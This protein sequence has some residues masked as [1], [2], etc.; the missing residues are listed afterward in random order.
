MQRLYRTLLSW[1]KS[2][3]RSVAFLPVPMMFFGLLVGILLYYL[4][5]NTDVSARF[6]EWLP[7]VMVSSQETARSILGLFVGGLIT[8][9]VFTFTQMMSLFNQV[10]NSYIPRLLPLFTGDRSLQ[11]TMGFYLATIIVTLIV[12]LS[13]RSDDGGY[14]PNLSVLFCIV[15]GVISLCM[16]MYFVTTISDKIKVSSIIESVYLRGVEML[17]REQKKKNFHRQALPPNLDDWYAIPSPIDGFIGTV[18]YP[19]LSILASKYGTRFYLGTELGTYVPRNYPLLQSEQKL[20]AGQIGK[21]MDAVSPVSHAYD[22]WYLPQINLLVEIALKALSPGINDPA[23]AIN[24]IDRLTGLLARLLSSPFYNFY[25][26]EG[27]GEVWV[28]RQQFEAIFAGVMGQ[29]RRY[30]REDPAVCR[31]LIR[32]LYHLYG[33]CGNRVSPRRCVRD[34]IMALI[35]DCRRY[36]VNPA[37][38]RAIAG[39]IYASRRLI[40]RLRENT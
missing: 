40:R 20:N 13:I 24:V 12:L 37:D 2:V 6:A 17:N 25:Q 28:V 3:V 9:V 19:H 16:F 31:R 22:D 26:A 14:V 35:D 5:L 29:L 18:N 34:E 15:C 39:E 38:R 7:A 36:L 23:T 27:G 30:G 32:M 8:L 33:E 10:A 11:L 21:V 1:T 4:E